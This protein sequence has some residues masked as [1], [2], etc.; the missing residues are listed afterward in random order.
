MLY[1]PEQGLV[2]PPQ[3]KILPGISLSTLRELAAE[4]AIPFTHRDIRPEEL[5]SAAEV[6]LCSTS[7]CMLPVVRC[8]GQAIGSGQ[9]G[10]IYRQ[11]LSAW[12]GQVGLDIA[13]Q[14]RA[15]L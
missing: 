15:F 4:L 5:A 8:N 9:P 14:A 10:P 6:Y 3:E 11:L 1:W 12:S 2:S 13:G 7:I